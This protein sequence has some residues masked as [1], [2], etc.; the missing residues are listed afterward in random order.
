MAVNTTAPANKLKIKLDKDGVIS[1]IGYYF[2]KT[3]Q[4]L[5]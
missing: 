1:T 4:K 5:I 3:C 2:N